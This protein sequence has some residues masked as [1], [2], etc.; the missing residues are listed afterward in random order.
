MDI[1]GVFFISL[2]LG[3]IP[4]YIADK[5]G[6]NFYL[7]W[8]FGALVFI[9]ALPVVFFVEPDQEANER[10]MINIGMKKCPYCAELIKGEAKICRFCGSKLTSAGNSDH[11]AAPG[12]AAIVKCTECHT[13]MRTAKSPGELEDCPR[14]KTVFEIPYE[15]AKGLVI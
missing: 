3:L 11:S 12:R 8:L 9:I 2:L 7:W 15:T 1:L 4:A 14:C 13:P 5:K 6:R 10:K